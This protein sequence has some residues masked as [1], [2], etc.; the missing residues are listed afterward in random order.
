MKSPGPGRPVV[1]F[2][3]LA[4]IG[5][6]S[7]SLLLAL[8]GTLGAISVLGLWV[9]QRECLTGVTYERTV[10]RERAMFAEEVSVD[11]TVTNDKFLPITWLHTE[12]ALSFRSPTLLGATVV[13]HAGGI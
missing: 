8:S 10:G 11:V 4:A 9:W 1:A 7:G 13:P 2:L 6:W 3:V 5:W 12:D